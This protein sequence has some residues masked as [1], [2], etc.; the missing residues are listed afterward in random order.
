VL[1]VF[2]FDDFQK[3]AEKKPNSPIVTL[4]WNRLINGERYP[5]Q[6]SVTDLAYEFDIPSGAEWHLYSAQEQAELRHCFYTFLYLWKKR[7]DIIHPI[8][9][10]AD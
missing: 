9:T 10:D 5:A 2:W 8:V 6:Y 4:V 3:Y 7:S 1:W